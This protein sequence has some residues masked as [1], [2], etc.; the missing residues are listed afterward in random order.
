MHLSF[1]EKQRI[2][3]INNQR[4]ELLLEEAKKQNSP[5]EQIQFIADYFLN[6]LP[7]ET[8]CKIDG[9]SESSFKD[10]KYDYSYLDDM[11]SE[12]IRQQT[13]REYA[14]GARAETLSAVDDFRVGNEHIAIFPT[15]FTLKMAT[16][17]IFANEIQR[18]CHELGIESKIVQELTHCYDKFDGK[19]TEGKAI[20]TDQIVKMMHY[21]NIITIDGVNYKLDLAGALT[22]LEFNKNHPEHAI[23]PNLFYFSTELDAKPYTML[24]E[25]NPPKIKNVNLVF[26]TSSYG[27]N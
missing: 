6:K 16:C 8:I 19:S 7:K 21:Y 12:H 27:P 14:P 25:S 24:A 9:T 26:N 15:T 13:S 3:Q 1:Q 2:Y 11:K 5:A 17:I 18:F 10:F 23:D 20:H 22:T 4:R